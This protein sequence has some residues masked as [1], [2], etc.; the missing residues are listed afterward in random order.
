MFYTNELKILDKIF[1][2]IK[3]SS[4]FEDLKSKQASLEE[5]SEAVVKDALKCGADECEVNIGGVK[6]LSVSSRDQ[7]IENIEYN[8]DNGMS[9]TIYKDKKSGSASTNDLSKDSI[10][11]AVVSA[12][13]IAQYA[14]VDDCSGLCDKDLICKDFKDLHLIFENQIDADYAAQKAIEIDT[15]AVENKIQG[16]K[17]S[18]GASFS[19]YLYTNVIANSNG[20]VKANS[21][22]SV[23]SGLTLLGVA[24]DKMQRGYGF[25]AVRDLKDLYAPERVVKEAIDRTLMKLNSQKVKTGKYNVIF[26]RSAVLSLWGHLASAIAGSAL[27]RNSSFLCDSL[28]KTVL[29]KS[30]S[31]FEDPFVIKGNGSRNYDGDGVAVKASNIVKDGVLEEYLLATYSGR[32]LGMKSNGHASGTH[33]W[34]VTFKDATTSFDELLE[35]VGEGIVVTDLMG[36]GVDMVSGNYSRGAEGYYFKDGKFVHAVD[37]I[38][39]AGN[40]KDMFMNMEAMADDYDERFKVKTGSVLIRDMTVSG[41]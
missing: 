16:I 5:I 29:S 37:G 36:Q 30:V 12:L 11:E 26:S 23:S 17:K 18:D 3:M 10:H 20:F 25:S 24:N 15:L 8:C 40:L 27:Y 38:T 21:A 7:D 33:N 28:G 13:N 31:I 22:S 19:S 14:D 34:F 41:L 39:I 9:I 2:G 4:F 6:G 1:V 32:K 35:N